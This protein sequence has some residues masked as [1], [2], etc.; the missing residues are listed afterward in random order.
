MPPYSTGHLFSVIFI[1]IKVVTFSLLC[2]FGSSLNQV[3][4]NELVAAYSEPD[5]STMASVLSLDDG[6]WSS[7]ADNFTHPFHDVNDDF[8]LVRQP[9]P[10]PVLAQVRPEYMP[11]SP[12]KVADPRPG[13]AKSLPDGT[14][15]SNTY[16]DLHIVSFFS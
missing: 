2:Y 14:A 1:S 10:P 6:S 8:P 12:S 15:G 13:P 3:E 11:I 9:S 7:Q 4:Q 5:K 16:Q